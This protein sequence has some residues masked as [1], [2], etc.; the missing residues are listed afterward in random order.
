MA[1]VVDYVVGN[2]ELAHRRGVNVPEPV[3]RKTFRSLDVVLER[4]EQKETTH[5]SLGTCELGDRGFKHSEISVGTP[6]DE[7]SAR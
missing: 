6:N 7:V 5:C 4:A 2:V 1:S 3:K